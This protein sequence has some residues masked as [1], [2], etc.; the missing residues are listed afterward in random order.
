MTKLKLETYF[1]EMNI[2]IQKLNRAIEVLEEL[3][4]IT[5]DK[6]EELNEI[7]K[8]KLD[9]LVFRFI[10]LQDLL[11]AKIFRNFLDYLEYPINSDFL[12]ILKEL[13]KENIVDIDTWSTFR[14]LRNT[15]AHD[16]PEDDEEKI[17][18]INYL[19]KN[20]KYLIEIGQ[21]IEAIYKTHR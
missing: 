12:S 3:Y 8:D 11:G 4:P 1:N 6:L 7:Q 15:I 17:E 16:Y 13:E 21:K 9:I 14:K 5:F 19:I 10:K 20:I 2:H 18:A